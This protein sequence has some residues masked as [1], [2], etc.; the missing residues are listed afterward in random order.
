[1]NCYGVS[2]RRV[3]ILELPSE[4]YSGSGWGGGGSGVFGEW[5]HTGRSS[6][7]SEIQGQLI[8]VIEIQI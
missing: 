1:M 5:L 3:L 8:T 6:S 2:W 4:W 7:S